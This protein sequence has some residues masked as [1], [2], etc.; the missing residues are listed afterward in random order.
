[1]I[2]AVGAPCFSPLRSCPIPPYGDIGLAVIALTKSLLI[3]SK[4]AKAEHH[5][6]KVEEM[7]EA[8]SSSH[9]GQRAANWG[10]N[11]QCIGWTLPMQSVIFSCDEMIR[12]GEPRLGPALSF[13]GPKGRGPRLA[14]TEGMDRETDAN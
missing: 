4:I 7:A 9:P 6:Q 11:R 10:M 3:S 2:F 1:M 13:K 12:H 5:Q 8:P 14:M